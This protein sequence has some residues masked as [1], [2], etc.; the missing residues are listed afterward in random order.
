MTPREKP[1]VPIWER[2]TLTVE[3][4]AAY[5]GIGKNKIR[6][7]T[8]DEDCPFVLWVGSKRLIKRKQ[9]DEFIERMYSI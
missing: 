9:L 1:Q 7:L 8:D 2:A 3:E 5:S 6:S 4:A